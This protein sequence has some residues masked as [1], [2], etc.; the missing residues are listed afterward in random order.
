VHAVIIAYRSGICGNIDTLHIAGT[1][2]KHGEHGMKW[3]SAHSTGGPEVLALA[4]FAGAV[5]LLPECVAA[6]PPA[7]AADA[8][9]REDAVRQALQGNPLLRTVRQ[10]RGLAEAAVVMARTYPFNPTFTSI[11]SHN[12]GPESA[13]ITNRVFTEDYVLLELELCGQRRHRRAAASAAATR[14]EWEIVQQELA[15]SIA[16]IRAYNTALYRQHKLEAA[17]ETIKLNQDAFESVRRLVDA[18][19]LR[20]ADRLLAATALEEVRAQRGQ[21]KTALSVARADLRRLLGTLDDSFTLLGTPDVPLVSQDQKAL[22]QLALVKRP[23]LQAKQAAVDEAEA[24]LRLIEANRFGNPQVGPI[25]AIDATQVVQIGGRVNVPLAVF[26]RKRGEIL[27]AKT[28]VAKVRSEAQELELRAAQDV[29]AAL[30]RFADA[31]SWAEAYEKEVVPNLLKTKQQ[32]EA[33]FANNEPGVDVSRVL[34]VQRAYLKAT[35]TLLDA[36]FELS[37]AEADLALAVAE[38]ALAL[39]SSQASP[40][41]PDSV[42][43]PALPPTVHLTPGLQRAD[44]LFL[45]V[46]AQLGKP[47]LVPEA[48]RD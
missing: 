29:Q 18:G 44:A 24:A 30:S 6:Q 20:A 21:A 17:E 8:L 1:I 42:S 36:R 26:N 45:P 39:A 25:F 19:K 10:Q 40:P 11:V 48:R 4:L 43:V 31:R 5:A 35:E 14:I 22:T 3:L 33:L 41:I 23:D 28:E 13:G 34:S 32:M 16:T 27:K 46:R 2:R 47:S 12:S 9:T 38:P 37:Q 15:I 7:F